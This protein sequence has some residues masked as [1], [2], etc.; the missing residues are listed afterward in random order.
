M[1]FLLFNSSVDVIVLLG[2]AWMTTN[3]VI[4]PAKK[5]LTLIHLRAA[6]RAGTAH[7]FLIKSLGKIRLQI[8]YQ[9][10]SVQFKK[11]NLLTQYLLQA[12]PFRS[13]PTE[14]D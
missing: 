14:Q 2:Y 7:G 11:L 9:I 12:L 10:C 4:Q 5:R 13:E 3:N 1:L 6:L 8:H